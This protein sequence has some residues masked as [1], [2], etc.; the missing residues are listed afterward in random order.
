MHRD[1]KPENIFLSPGAGGGPG[2][3]RC[4]ARRGTSRATS[5]SVHTTWR[6]GDLGSAVELAE[7]MQPGAPGLFLEVGRV[8]FCGRGRRLG[9]A[10]VEARV[11]C[12]LE[13]SC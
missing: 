3:A 10:G 8:G 13:A 9:S 6:L 12:R 7:V 4:G 1:I 11:W 2:A 5:G